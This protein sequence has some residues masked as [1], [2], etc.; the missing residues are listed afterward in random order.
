MQ[1]SSCLLLVSAQPHLLFQPHLSV[2]DQE[3]SS[4]GLLTMK[5]RIS[6]GILN[7]CIPRRSWVSRALDRHCSVL[8]HLV[9]MPGFLL[10]FLIIL[11]N[12]VL[13]IDLRQ[14]FLSYQSTPYLASILLSTSFPCPSWSLGSLCIENFLRAITIVTWSLYLL[15]NLP[16]YQTHPSSP[17]YVLVY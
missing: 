17:S 16:L 8:V 13:E 2:P 4:S 5:S 15:A 7:Y 14:E 9:L 3:Q 6:P 10:G 1:T 11:P 12:P